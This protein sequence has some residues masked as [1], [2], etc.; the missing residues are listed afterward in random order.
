MAASEDGWKVVFL[1]KTG[2]LIFCGLLY[3]IFGKKQA[4][5]PVIPAFFSGS[6]GPFRHLLFRQAV[7]C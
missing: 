3:I 5:F 2:C 1:K 7:L 4:H 6:A